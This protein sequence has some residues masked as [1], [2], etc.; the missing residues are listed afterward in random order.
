V[1]TVFTVDHITYSRHEKLGRPPMVKV[2][3]YCGLRSFSEYVCIE[4]EGFAQ[5]KA[6]QWWRERSSFNSNDKGSPFPISTDAALEQSSALFTATHLR[7]WVNKQYPEILAHC[8]DGTAFGKQVEPASAP[9][10][11]TYSKPAYQYGPHAQPAD[12]PF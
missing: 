12:I 10:T 11:N 1:E 4:H 8:F 5:R 2:T 7:V 3:Y 6:R 9:S